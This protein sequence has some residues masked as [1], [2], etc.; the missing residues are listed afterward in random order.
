MKIIK[1]IIFLS[2]LGGTFLIV[3]RNCDRKG[4][5]RWWASLKMAALAAAILAGL[6]PTRTKAI[7]PS[8]NNCK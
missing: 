5:G 4:L 1:Y 6:I 8:V 2:V 3:Y 7:K